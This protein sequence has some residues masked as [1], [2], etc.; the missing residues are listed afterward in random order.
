MA[1]EYKS[2]LVA[3]SITVLNEIAPLYKHTKYRPNNKAII[4]ITIIQS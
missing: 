3:I 4:A 1:P 2:I